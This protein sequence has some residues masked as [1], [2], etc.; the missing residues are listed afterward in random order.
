MCR[1]DLSTA[2]IEF[3]SPARVSLATGTSLTLM[4]MTAMVAARVKIFNAATSP[5]LN[6]DGGRQDQMTR[7]TDAS[8]CE[9]TDSGWEDSC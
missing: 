9:P 1:S 2:C 7:V 5:I 8:I 6:Q 3:M 4:S